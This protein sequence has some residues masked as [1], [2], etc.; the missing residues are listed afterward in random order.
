VH[1]VS[2]YNIVSIVIMVY[3]LAVYFLQD[4]LWGSYQCFFFKHSKGQETPSGV[5]CQDVEGMEGYVPQVSTGRK[6]VRRGWRLPRG[7]VMAKAPH[8]GFYF[9][10]G[11]CV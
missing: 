3:V 6:P 5:L 7:W 10:S 4:V 2:F 11:F 1:L 9:P 8:V